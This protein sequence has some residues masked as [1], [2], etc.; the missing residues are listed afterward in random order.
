MREKKSGLVKSTLVITVCSLIGIIISFVSQIVIANYFGAKFERDAYFVASTVPTYL[1]AIFIGSIGVVFLP[2]VVEI[3]ANETIELSKWLSTIFFTFI[4][5]SLILVFLCVILSKQIIGFIATGYEEKQIQFAS[6][7]LIV[8]ILTFPLSVLNNL[9]SSLYQIKNSFFYPA[10][11]PIISAVISLVCV[12]VLSDKIG[13]YSL[14]LGLLFGSVFS[15]AFLLPI[16]RTYKVRFMICL[17]DPMFLSFIK[18]FIPLLITGILFRST[19]I[20][21]RSF[22][23]NMEVGSISYLGYSSQILAILALLTSSGIGL[24]IYPRFSRLWAEKKKTEFNSFF[25]K[26]I[27]IILLL[28]IP[29][30][31]VVVFYGDIFIQTIFERG[32]FSHSVTLAVTKALSWSMGAF[33]FQNLGNVVSKIFYISGKTTAISIIGSIELFIY[34]LL[35]F[36]LSPYFSFIGLS[37]ALSISSMINIILSMLYINNKL[38]KLEFKKLFIDVFKILFSSVLSISVVLLFYNYIIGLDGLGCLVVSL[39]FGFFTYVLLG[40]LLGV[41]EIVYFKSRLSLKKIFRN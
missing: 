34:I 1:S 20:F 41:E 39:I 15:L 27:R 33:V 23:S 12:I 22:A 26:I 8:I 13:I 24:T 38:C 10:I 17:K 37:I 7:I 29:I 40:L 32:A 6:N 36:L 35:G 19:S 3:K 16:L 28:S 14:A 31:L 5:F 9:L 11:A 21:E 2:K 18:T 30:S 4:F 25:V